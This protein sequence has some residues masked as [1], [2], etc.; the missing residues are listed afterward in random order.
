MK[1]KNENIMKNSGMIFFILLIFSAP[2]AMAQDFDDYDIDTD[3]LI[4]E[5]EFN[6]AHDWG[7]PDWDQDGNE[8]LN[9]DE[10][11]EFTY[12]TIDVDD[13]MEISR[14]EW[15]DGFEMYGDQ[16][17]DFSQFD[18]DGDEIIT[19]EEF[20]NEMEDS[21]YF[22]EIDK[23]ND[24]NID[25]SELDEKIFD[26]YDENEDERLDEEEFQEFTYMDSF[27]YI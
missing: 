7:L 13:D 18:T 12:N 4:D 27:D 24:G 25:E 20:I 21:E 23:N 2:V 9:D 26:D 10:F 5:N 15:E 14:T 19:S 8:M 11:N 17:E 16:T 3:G 22:N 1:N 6:E